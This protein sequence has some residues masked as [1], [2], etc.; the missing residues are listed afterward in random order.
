MFALLDGDIIAYRCAASAEGD[1]SKVA[2]Y[3]TSDMM[4]GI[5]RD[6]RASHFQVY[7][8]GP[9]NFRYRLYPEYKA[10]RI[11]IPR[12]QWLND[13]KEHLCVQWGGKIGDDVEADDMLGIHQTALT[14]TDLDPMIL[15]IDKDLQQVPGR[16]YNFVTKEETYVTPTAGWYTFFRHVMCGDSTDNVPGCRG[17]GPVKAGLLLQGCESPLEMYKQC[18]RVFADDTRFLLMCQLIWV[19]RQEEQQWN[20][21]LCLSLHPQL[22]SPSDLEHKWEASELPLEQN[23]PSLATIGQ[24]P[25]G[26]LITGTTMA[27][28]ELIKNPVLLT[29]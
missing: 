8:S 16:H 21:Q 20:P 12:P 25:D 13:C 18:R 28:T 10:N 22:S 9:T 11:K 27:P 19:R 6:T 23:G 15:T 2:V 17:I 24:I 29:S 3:R 4:E 14:D 5:L 26:S 7:I 1:N